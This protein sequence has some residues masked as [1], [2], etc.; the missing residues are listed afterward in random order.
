MARKTYVPT[1]VWLLHR[2]C[3]Y[4]ARYRSVIVEYLPEGGSAALDAVLLAC[5]AF[6]ALVPDHSN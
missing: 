4:I 6:M 1:L 5:E 3:V 2:V